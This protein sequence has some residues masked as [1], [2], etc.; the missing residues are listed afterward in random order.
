MSI[1][2]TFCPK[3]ANSFGTQNWSSYADLVNAR[4]PG[5]SFDLKGIN[6]QDS[7][8]IIPFRKRANC[9]WEIGFILEELP[10][11]HNGYLSAFPSK[12]IESNQ[13]PEETAK[14]KILQEGK[15]V[16]DS[17]IQIGVPD[18][19]FLHI[20]NEQIYLFITKIIEEE[21]KNTLEEGKFISDDSLIWMT[22]DIFKETIIEQ[23][24]SN[25]PLLP[26]APMKGVSLISINKLLALKVEPGEWFIDK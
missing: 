12:I 2:K 17:L 13:N 7:V 15:Y 20:C 16:I 5:M 11:F 10:L 14:L 21:E 19:P 8:M 24:L 23:Q 22:W 1:S 18:M 4:F 25:V 9:K 3:N 26:G 6:S